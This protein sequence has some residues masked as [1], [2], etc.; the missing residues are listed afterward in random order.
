MV[1]GGSKFG[2]A[3]SWQSTYELVC[4]NVATGAKKVV[5]AHARDL[6]EAYDRAFKAL[7]RLTG[8]RSYVVESA[9][10]VAYG[11]TR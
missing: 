6:T 7:D 9:V 11:D 8:D 3:F 1:V 5:T 10:T 2:T 4:R